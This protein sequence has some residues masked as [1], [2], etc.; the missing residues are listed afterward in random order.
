MSKRF[1]DTNK[2]KKPFIRGLKGAYKVLWDY[3]CLDCDHAGIWQ[4]DFEIAQIYIGKDLPVNAKEA[5]KFFNEGE[6]RIVPLDDGKK[7]FIKP[8]IDFQYGPLNPDNRLHNSVIKSLNRHNLKVQQKDL[9]S[10]L[11]GAKDKDKDKVKDKDNV[12]STEFLTFWNIYPKKVGK[13]QAY[14]A[15]KKIKGIADLLPEILKAVELQ[16]VCPQW[17]KDG[18]QFI[19]NPATWLNGSRWEDEVQK[20]PMQAMVDEMNRKDLEHEQNRIQAMCC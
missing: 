13:G 17:K 19:P 14:R 20:D 3:I 6:E 18:G 11:E 16:S 5:L 12:Y 1:E 2:Y 4:A 15:W 8:F 10:P 7:W 9:I